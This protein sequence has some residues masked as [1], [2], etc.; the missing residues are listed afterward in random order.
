MRVIKFRAWDNWMKEMIQPK[1][2]DFIAWHAMSNWREYLVV[3]QYTGLKDSRGIE[4]YEG[5]VVKW[6]DSSNGKYWRVAKVEWDDRGQWCYKIMPNLCIDCFKER[7]GDKK[8]GLGN[9]IYTPEPSMYGNVLEVIGNIYET[10][11]LLE[12]DQ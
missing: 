10:P 11:E 7:S 5:D 8:F 4:I 9:F 3:M 6:D 12:P 2:G 1:G